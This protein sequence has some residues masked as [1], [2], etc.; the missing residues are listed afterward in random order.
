MPIV[1]RIAQTETMER[2]KKRERG[3]PTVLTPGVTDTIL[4]LVRAGNY[5]EVAAAAEECGQ[6]EVT[7]P[8]G[9]EE[10]HAP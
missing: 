8:I 10:S 6:V 7:A 2:N 1:G 9:E 3:R 5:L 4:T